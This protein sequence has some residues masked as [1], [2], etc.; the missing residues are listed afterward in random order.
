MTVPV[1]EVIGRYLKYVTWRSPDKYPLRLTLKAYQGADVII[2]PRFAFGQPVLKRVG[3]TVQPKFG[4]IRMAQR[5]RM[6]PPLKQEGRMS[7]PAPEVPASAL[8]GVSYATA[9]SVCGAP[10][11]RDLIFEDDAIV[12]PAPGRAWRHADGST[13]TATA[14]CPAR[15]RSS[16]SYSTQTRHD[17]VY[18]ARNASRCSRCGGKIKRDGGHFVP[19]AGIFGMTRS[20]MYKAMEPWTA[21]A[22]L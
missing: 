22:K 16:K 13:R 2:D 6:H 15:R 21:Q 3:L 10:G 5:V 1:G 8:G 14:A 11:C 20:T 7:A 12:R 9:T 18:G 17:R 4:R 19:D